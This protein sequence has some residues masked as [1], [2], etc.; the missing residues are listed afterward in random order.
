MLSQGGGWDFASHVRK[1]SF[2]GGKGPINTLAGII[3]LFKVY[4][5][6]RNK[7]CATIHKEKGFELSKNNPTQPKEEC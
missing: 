2:L 4:N 3:D 5:F 6:R 7:W 1:W